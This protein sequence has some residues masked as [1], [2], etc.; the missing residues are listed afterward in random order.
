MAV[1]STFRP[2]ISTNSGVTWVTV[3]NGPAWGVD[4]QG[5]VVMSADGTTIIAALTTNPHTSVYI[6]T[7]YGGSWTQTSVLSSNIFGIVVAC[8]GD[9]TKLI[10][11]IANGPICF[12]TNSGL[13]WYPASV[14]NGLQ[15]EDWV[16]VASSADG[17]HMAAV[18]NGGNLFFSTN[19][20][21][22]WAPTSLPV[23]SW[24]S[25]CLS[26]DGKWVGATSAGNSYIS[27]NAGASWITNK[28]NGDAI[29]CS[30]NG[31][32]WV[33]AGAQIYSSSDGGV[34]WQT[35]L[36]ASQWVDGVVSADGCEF[37]VT[38]APGLWA[39]RTTPSPQL[40]V[41][42]VNTNV[43]LSWLVPSTN[44]VLQQNSDLGSANWIAVSNLPILNFTN[45]QDEV[46]V[47]VSASNGFFRL[48][49][50]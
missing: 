28:L 4:H 27:S 29:A 10:S 42:T 41:Q 47:P 31:N 50:Q 37:L 18:V 15:N 13:N 30:A 6:S 26:S 40:S 19:F 22:L 16:S 49:G 20:G 43:A 1:P 17:Q 25:V 44:F 34:T 39:T 38:G 11:G 23:Q 21:A 2:V 12:S 48:I 5:G 36:A 7:N 32:N 45:L 8:S 33:I 14:I 3:T 9:A 46:S 35:N 24:T